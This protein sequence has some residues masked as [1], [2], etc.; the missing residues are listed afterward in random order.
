LLL[1]EYVRNRGKIYHR[2]GGNVL[3]VFVCLLTELLKN[4]DQTFLK[5]YG[6]V[7][8]NLGTNPLDYQWHWPKVKVTR[9]QKAAIVYFTTN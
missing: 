1:V 5:V 7:G 2:Q 6:I 4:T 9:D 3:P 8:H